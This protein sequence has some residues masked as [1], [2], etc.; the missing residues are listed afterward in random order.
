[1]AFNL[2]LDFS[3]QSLCSSA[4]K[5]SLFPVRSGNDWTGIEPNLDIF[6]P[7][8]GGVD[9]RDWIAIITLDKYVWLPREESCT[10]GIGFE[11][12]CMLSLGLQILFSFCSKC[13]PILIGTARAVLYFRVY[14]LW[15]IFFPAERCCLA[16]YQRLFVWNKLSTPDWDIDWQRM[17]DLASLTL[18]ILSLLLPGQRGLWPD[19]WGAGG[20]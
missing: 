10:K 1:M 11:S 15:D 13:N 8:L 12:I 17:N 6:F 16:T 5:L 9:E 19:D 4:R 20:A 3:L 18:H 14:S 2:V 7:F